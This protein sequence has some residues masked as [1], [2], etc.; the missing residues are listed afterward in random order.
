MCFYLFFIQTCLL[1]T[2]GLDAVP[3][4]FCMESASDVLK[5]AQPV[6]GPVSHFIMLILFNVSLCEP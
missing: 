2:F 4:I 6:S 1:H 3:I 5:A